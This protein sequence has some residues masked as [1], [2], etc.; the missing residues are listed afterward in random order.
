MTA[1]ATHPNLERSWLGDLEDEAIHILREVVGQFERPV[2]LFSG[3][4]DSIVLLHL[5][6]KAFWPDGCRSRSCT[7]TPATTFPRSSSSA[8]ACRAT[9]R[10]SRR[11]QR[12]G[13]DRP[14]PR[15]GD[16]LGQSR[17]PLQTVTLLDAHRRA[18]V[19]RGARRRAPRR[20]EGPRQ[21][22]GLQRPR[23]LRAVGSAQSAPG[24]VG[25][26]QRPAPAA[27]STCAFSPCRTG[28]NSTSGPTSRARASRCR[29]STTPIRDR[30][31]AATGCCSRSPSGP[32]R[33]RARQ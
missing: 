12:A 9:R 27:A 23:R 19:R 26:V 6:T 5:A 2:L 31:S 10:Q 18:P 15:S 32:S 25:P 13:L 22:A 1:V 29:A 4:K 28:L 14:R 24:A 17:N 3:G 11:G 20:G 8:T 33:P 21:G 7:S 16:R 30:S